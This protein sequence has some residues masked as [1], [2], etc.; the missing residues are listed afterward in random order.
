MITENVET[1]FKKKSNSG[2]T[3]TALFSYNDLVIFTNIGDSMI[4]KIS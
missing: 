4:Y 2:T 1:K 3:M